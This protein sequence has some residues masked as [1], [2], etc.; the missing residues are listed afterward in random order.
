MT[1][2]VMYVGTPD[3]PT[4]FVP[5]LGCEVG[6]FTQEPGGKFPALRYHVPPTCRGPFR[7]KDLANYD[8]TKNYRTDQ[9]GLML[10]YAKTLAGERCKR[11]A[12]NRYPRC[13]FHGGR[14]H[15]LDKMLDDIDDEN[16]EAVKLSRYQQFLAKQITV[17]DLDDEELMS[18]GFRDERGRIFKPRNIPREMVQ[19]MTRGIYDRALHE[20]KVNAVEATKTLASI[21]VDLTNDASIRLKAAEAILDRTLGKA[22]QVVAITGTAAWEEVFEGIGTVSREESRR[23]RGLAVEENSATSLPTLDAEVVPELPAGGNATQQDSQPD[24]LQSR[25]RRLT[26]RQPPDQQ[27]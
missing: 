7:P 25:I 14:V 4:K 12:V 1:Q 8:E 3:G 9:Y 5:E 13:N 26:V 23:A 17:E 10:C 19:A 15:P 21:M 11:K 22:P 20:L 24:T 2:P 6:T 27:Q 16:G 18:F